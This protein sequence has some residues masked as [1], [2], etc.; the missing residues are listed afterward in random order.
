MTFKNLF[1]FIIYLSSTIAFSQKNKIYFDEDWEQLKN[2]RY[3]AYYRILTKTDSGY[4]AQDYYMSGKIQMDGF[5]F[6]KKCITY[7]GKF[8]WYDEQGAVTKSATYLMDLAEGEYFEYHPNGQIKIKDFYIKG[9]RNGLYEEFYQHGNLRARAMFINDQF[10]GSPYRYFEDGS[11]LVKMELDV[12]GNGEFLEYHENGNLRTTGTIEEGF[13]KGEWTNYH[14]NGT[15]YYITEED[16]KEYYKQEQL[17]LNL[18]KPGDK[19][20]PAHNSLNTLFFSDYDFDI[21]EEDRMVVSPDVD[22]EF[23]GGYEAMNLYIQNNLVYPDK[24]VKR[25]KR[26]TVYVLFVIEADG[27][28]SNVSTDSGPMCLRAESIRIVQNMP[29]WSPGEFQGEN[30]RSF[31]QLPLTFD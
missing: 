2:D 16:D 24:A 1:L 7:N 26:G 17:D 15:V 20:D 30:V 3:A 21:S 13:S 23:I 11:P 25:K 18:I 12:E 6:D 19:Q 27:S 4:R 9:K 22:A 8:V 29:D 5:F 14:S 10:D 28:I 31:Y